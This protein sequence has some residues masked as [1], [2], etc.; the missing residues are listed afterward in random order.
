MGL[1]NRKS[2]D[3][4]SREH[5]L[6]IL[7]KLSNVN[8]AEIQEI[9]DFITKPQDSESNNKQSPDIQKYLE[10]VSSLFGRTSLT[11]DLSSLSDREQLYQIYDEMDESTTHITAALD[12]LS[13]DATQPDELGHILTIESDSEKVTSLLTDMVED[14]ELEAKLSKWARS[15]AK[16]GDMFV[17][18]GA[19]EGV[20]VINID[21]TIYPSAVERLDYKGNLLAFKELKSLSSVAGEDLLPPWEY[22][23]FKHKGELQKNNNTARFSSTTSYSFTSSYGQSILKSAIKVY[24]QLRFVENLLILSRLT[25]SVRRNIFLINTGNLDPANSFETISNYARLLKKNINLDIDNRVF[26]ASK[27]TFSYDED[28]FLPVSDTRND[29][30]IEQTG[31]DVNIS[32]QYDLEYLL[33]KLFAA[34]KIPKAYLNYEQDL[35]ARSTLIQLD[36]RY[37]RSVGQ[38]QNTLLSGLDRLARIHLTYNGLDPDSVNFDLRLTSVSSIDAEARLE[39]KTQRISAAKDMW[40]LLV[41][42]NNNLQEIK[43]NSVEL[44]PP[45]GGDSDFS[46]GGDLG[47]E[48]PSLPGDDTDISKVEP[49]RDTGGSGGMESYAD[50]AKG[51]SESVRLKEVGVGDSSAKSPLDLQY[52]ASM[53][54]KEYLGLSAEDVGTLLREKKDLSEK[55]RKTKLR[56]SRRTTLY[57]KDLNS[58]YPNPQGIEGFNNLVSNLKETDKI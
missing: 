1:F 12:I 6:S 15:V 51:P 48:E 41:E 53:L 50:F 5:T 37:A 10:I 36:I 22:I 3:Q 27:H 24:S 40:E 20:G 16:Y 31:G 17:K 44:T 57:Y 58:S 49:V 42:M 7:K 34:L 8:Q 39:Q 19:Q 26:N 23:H 38:L 46:K 33:N 14:L 56:E 29:V 25:N 55:A 52:A 18:I 21:D 13:D 35:N 30:R 32:E 45:T 54:F 43:E 47:P 11:N 9:V 4:E 2:K 28:I